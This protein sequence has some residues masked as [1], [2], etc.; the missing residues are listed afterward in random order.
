VRR[1]KEET[2]TVTRQQIVD[3][4]RSYVGL[5]YNSGLPSRGLLL[6]V[7]DR[8]GLPNGVALRAKLKQD[9]L[10]GDVMVVRITKTQAQNAIGV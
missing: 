7:A 9:M 10:P 4:A 5:P 6:A 3:A 2:L 1:F 8:L